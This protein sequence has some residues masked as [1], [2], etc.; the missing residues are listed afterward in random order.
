MDISHDVLLSALSAKELQD[1]AIRA[2]KLER[3]WMKPEPQIKKLTRAIHN[4]DDMYVDAMTL[5]PGAKWL[6]T[7][8]RGKSSSRITL[9]SLDNVEDVRSAAILHFPR[10]HDSYGSGIHQ[11]GSAILAVSMLVDNQKWV[12]VAAQQD[13]Y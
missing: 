4:T 9:W 5:L 3:N 7:A 11:D 10:C 1:L 8:Q 12:V 2:I 6:V 13:Q